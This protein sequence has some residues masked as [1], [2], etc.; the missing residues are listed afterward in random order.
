MNTEDQLGKRDYVEIGKM[1]CFVAYKIINGKYN[2]IIA[3][4]GTDGYSSGCF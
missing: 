2:V 3:F 1:Q 4:Q